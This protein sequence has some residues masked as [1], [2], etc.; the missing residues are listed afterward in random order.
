MT[1]AT[2]SSNWRLKQLLQGFAD[3]DDNQDCD[4]HA[5]SNDSRRILPGAL[6][7]ACAGHENHGLDFIEDVYQAGVAAI[8][9]EPAEGYSLSQLDNE[10]AARVPHIAIK[11]LSW[12]LGLIADR[13]YGQP[14]SQLTVIGITGTDGKTSCCHFIARALQQLTET[15]VGIIGT[16]G[17]G[18]LDQPEAASHT[19]PDAL[20]THQL[21]EHMREQGAHAVVMEV[22]SHALH[23]GRVQGVHFNVAVLTNISRD[24]LDYHGDMDSYADAKRRLFTLPGLEQ[25]I[26][27]GDDA[28]GQ[29]WAS[30]L[31][32]RIPTTTYGA[33]APTDPQHHVSFTNENLDRKGLH[34]EAITPWG[35]AHLD[36]SLYGRFNLYNLSAVISTLGVLGIAWRD[37]TE[38]VEMLTHVAGRMEIISPVNS[39]AQPVVVIDFAHTAAALEQVLSALTEHHFGKI[40]CVFGCGGDRD[41][42]KRPLMGEIAESLADQVILTDDNPRTEQGEQIIAEILTGFSSPEKVHIERNRYAAIEWAIQHANQKDVVLIAGKGHE[43]YQIIGDQKQ[44]F[45]DKETAQTILKRGLH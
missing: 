22:S 41:R 1:V 4:I 34:W 14:S 44:P 40:W 31:V 12:Q 39:H 16:L 42:G 25:A 13:F 36:S 3:V 33:K 38:K 23:Q 29:Q 8:V 6:F 26:L 15:P 18:L 30:E 28:Y 32:S 45:S 5:L 10:W 27:N 37:I 9:W 11:D 19:T 35:H 20:R 24:H 7:I 21:I 43:D 17:Y 2:S